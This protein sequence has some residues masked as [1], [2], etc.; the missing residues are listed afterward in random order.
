MKFL[1]YLVIIGLIFISCKSVT[2]VEKPEDLIPEPEM[3]DIL[4]DLHL[5]SSTYNINNKQALKGVNYISIVKD[6]Y[7]IDSVKFEK[8][9]AYY[10]SNV[11]T[12][13][14]MF[15][16][17]ESRIN[18]LKKNYETEMDSL[19]LRDEILEEQNSAGKEKN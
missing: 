10:A 18:A 9:N 13:L 12:Y 19:I 16:K 17:V 14:K 6:K 3:V 1:K 2:D 4:V 8:S 15:K 5:A 7:G 11:D